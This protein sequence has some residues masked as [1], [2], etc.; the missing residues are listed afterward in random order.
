MVQ[1]KFL[2]TVQKIFLKMQKDSM[3]E[4]GRNFFLQFQK[5]FLELQKI[6]YVWSKRTGQLR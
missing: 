4:N 2:Q 6:F 1:K 3:E 5:T